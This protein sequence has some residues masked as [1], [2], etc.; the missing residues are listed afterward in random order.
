MAQE[1]HAFI[2]KS[3][4][5]A[6]SEVA[7][8][9]SSRGWRVEIPGAAALDAVGSRLEIQVDGKPLQLG[10]KIAHASDPDFAAPAQSADP[11]VLQGVLKAADF[12]IAFVGD[13]QDAE[14]WARDAAR[15]LAL[16]ATGAFANPQRNTLLHYGG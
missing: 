9:M 5:P 7:R 4:L 10:V 13:G 12:R 15:A 11:G 3:K 8:A 16:L 2:K 6:A 14:T 1:F